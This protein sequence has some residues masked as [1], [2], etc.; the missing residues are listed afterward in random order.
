MR[1][2]VL[3]LVAGCAS[4]PP[5]TVLVVERPVYVYV[6]EKSGP[7]VPPGPGIGESSLVAIAREERAAFEAKRAPEVSYVV[8][9]TPR[10]V[11]PYYVPTPQS[12]VIVR[13][14]P[15]AE[16]K[17]TRWHYD[18]AVERCDRRGTKWARERCYRRE[19]R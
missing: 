12:V 5:P 13:D 10:Y 4:A 7:P 3:L 19:A 14:L 17:H 1:L 18:R 8:D 15:R 9:S 2:A 16:R 6:P 11:E